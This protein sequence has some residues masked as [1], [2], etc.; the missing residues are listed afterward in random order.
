MQPVRVYATQTREAKRKGAKE[1]LK[2][3]RAFAESATRA[4]IVYRYTLQQPRVAQRE[5]AKAK[6]HSDRLAKNSS[7]VHCAAR[8]I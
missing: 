8:E 4:K 1:G 5:R 7:R 2:D 6:V 3:V